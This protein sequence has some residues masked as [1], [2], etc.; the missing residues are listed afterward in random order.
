MEITKTFTCMII[1]KR[2]IVNLDEINGNFMNKK[3]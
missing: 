3:K 1:E 2:E